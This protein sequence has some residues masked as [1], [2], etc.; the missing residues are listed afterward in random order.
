MK[1]VLAV[2]I[3]AILVFSLCTFS[4]SAAGTY[5]TN[6]KKVVDFLGSKETY[7]VGTKDFTF[8]I[9]VQYVNQ[10]KAY[11]VSTEGDITPEQAEAIIAFVKEGEAIVKEN[12]TENPAYLKGD[13]VDFTRFPY[14]DRKAI[15]RKGQQACEVVGLTL[16]F[17]GEYVVITDESGAVLFK[18]EPI[19]KTTGAEFNYAALVIALGAF[20]VIISG[21]LFTAKKVK[22]F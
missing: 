6:E 21:A 18:D 2:V 16:V 4:A 19:I 15:L 11:F 14:A 9:P 10:A 12:L 13:E 7:K 20:V 3:S 17:D 1:K 22:L 8:I 5:G